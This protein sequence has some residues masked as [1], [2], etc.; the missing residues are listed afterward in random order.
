MQLN[1]NAIDLLKK[2]ILVKSLMKQHGNNYLN[3]LH[4]QLLMLK[5]LKHRKNTGKMSF[6][7]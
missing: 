4:Y 7:I 5:K 1:E 3:E 6:M 2:D